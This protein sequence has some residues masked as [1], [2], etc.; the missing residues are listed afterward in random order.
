MDR[1][2]VGGVF[3]V[4]ALLSF[5][6]LTAKNYAT[7]SAKREEGRWRTAREE[8]GV[9]I[10]RIHNRVPGRDFEGILRE[11]TTA[12]EAQSVVCTLPGGVPIRSAH[13]GE[14]LKI[15]A[16]DVRLTYHRLNRTYVARVSMRPNHY[17]RPESWWW[18]SP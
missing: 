1:I 9:I 17:L 8:I 2:N 16:M 15:E 12:V 3:L 14:L 18:E 11:C 10:T 6:G 7:E 4:V 5:F 13:A